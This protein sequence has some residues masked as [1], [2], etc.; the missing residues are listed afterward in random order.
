MLQKAF[1]LK[2]L[3]HYSGKSKDMGL[4]TLEMK[5]IPNKHQMYQ[6]SIE[7]LLASFSFHKE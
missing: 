5:Y 3:W 1:I 4:S 2:Y 6:A 7:E